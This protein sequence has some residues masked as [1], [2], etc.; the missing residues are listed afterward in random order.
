MHILARIFAPARIILRQK[1]WVGPMGPW[2]HGPMGPM[3]PCAPWAHGPLY[4]IMLY[5]FIL[6]YIVLYYIIL[7]YPHLI[8]PPL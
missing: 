6:Y 8:N 5:Y 3:G 7:Y 2:A 1:K 4:Y